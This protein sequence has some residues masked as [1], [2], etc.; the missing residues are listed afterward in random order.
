MRGRAQHDRADRQHGDHREQ[1]EPRVAGVERELE[2]LGVVHLHERRQT[3]GR[4]RPG[5]ERDD[6]EQPEDRLRDQRRDDRGDARARD[7]APGGVDAHEVAAAYR[8]DRVGAD[9][10]QVGPER[11]ARADL[12]PGERAAQDVPPDPG[13]DAEAQRVQREGEDEE[14]QAYVAQAIA[15]RRDRI[16]EGGDRLA[17]AASPSG[18]SPTIMPP[19]PGRDRRALALLVGGVVGRRQDPAPLALTRTACTVAVVTPS[20]DVVRTEIAVAGRRLAGDVDRVGV[21]VEHF[22]LLQ[23]EA[24]VALACHVARRGRRLPGRPDGACPTA[25]RTGRA[26]T[27]S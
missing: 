18:A 4:D 13:A 8:C 25:D 10:G 16:A 5:A 2:G 3:S 7:Q 11:A 20:S 19:L 21:R 26:R 9:P 6:H 1:H 23:I 27:V 12:A 17:H 15:E 22:E 24:R 14:Q